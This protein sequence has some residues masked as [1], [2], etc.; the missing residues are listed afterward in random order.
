MTQ[1]PSA[2]G[3]EARPAAGA[4]PPVL[5]IRDLCVSF[6]TDEGAVRA[7]DRVSLSIGRGEVLGL[8]GESGCGKSVTAL[9][10]LRLIPS[11]PGRID[12]GCVRFHGRDLLAMPARELSAVRGQAIGMIFQEPMAALSPLHRVGAQLAEALRLH[13]AIGRREAWD[14][15]AQWLRRVGIPDAEEKLHAYPHQLSGGMAQRVMIAIALM[16][17]PELLIADEPTTAL[18]VTIQAQIL[19]LI[20]GL[21]DR[22]TAVLLITHDMGVIREMA[23]RVAVMYASEIVESGPVDALFR[24]PLHPYTRALLASIPSLARRP[25]RLP[26]IPGQVPAPLAYPAGCR[27]RERCPFAFGRCAGEHPALLPAGDG[28]AAACFLLQK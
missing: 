2:N 14:T 21:R 4:A 12:S 24:D 9:S 18:D 15:A 10:I 23:D 25:A 26:V 13:R 5:E 27:F 20:R 28:R 11:P 22:D 7:V 8:V 1:D 19:D 16:L 3:S 17:R 6:A